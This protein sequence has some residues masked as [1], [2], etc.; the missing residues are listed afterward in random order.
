MTVLNSAKSVEAIKEVGYHNCAQ[1]LYLQV[2][3]QGTKSWLYRYTSPLTQT[4]REMGLGSFN[5][6]SLAQARQYAIEG[7]RLV[8]NGQDPIEERKKEQIKVQLKQARNLTF[9]EIA[10]ACIAAKAPEWKN[11]K[12]SQQW[13]NSLEAYAFPILG[14]LPI[15][16]IT[17]DL[18]LKALEPIW[19]T[20]AE[21]ASRVRQ[22]IETIWDWAR[23][24][25]YVEGENPARLR[26]HLD[27]I[28]AKT[29][30]VKRVRH[31]PAVPYKE[32]QKFITALHK[33][34]GSSALALEFMILTAGRTGE[35]IGAK[36]S[37]IDLGTD[38]WTVPAD[39]MKAGREHRV[40][41][42][43]RAL[44]ILGSIKSNCNPDE[45]VFPGW[46]A[47][48]GLSNG[49]MLALMRK[50][51]FGHFTPHGFRSTFRDWAAEEAHSFQ[52]E[53]IELALAHTIKNQAEA[54]YRRGDQLE[55]RRELMKAWHSYVE[56][57]K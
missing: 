13:N 38:V 26:G 35:V 3:K 5:F 50:M 43:A 19:I 52:N 1:G 11:A 45:F 6:V 30:K 46:K 51:Q 48:T 47:G 9:K 54:A 8:I 42:C 24:R 55:R 49:A 4:R 18:I 40:P 36:W 14:E 34:S 37:E 15:S 22:R 57:Q 27:K 53:T 28:L 29:A 41:L 16:D 44:A 25:K 12:H 56:A 20:K 7:K 39:R 10:E 32:I 23:A 17:T 2:S 31:H 33:R 21:T